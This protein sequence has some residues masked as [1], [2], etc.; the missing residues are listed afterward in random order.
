[1]S[2]DEQHYR[3]EVT[4]FRHG[5]NR[6]RAAGRGARGTPTGGRGVSAGRTP[7]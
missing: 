2:T 7:G 4:G 1:M 6:A 3:S 5:L